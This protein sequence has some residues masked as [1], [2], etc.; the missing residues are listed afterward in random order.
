MVYLGIYGYIRYIWVYEAILEYIGV[1][2]GILLIFGYI[3]VDKG[4]FEYFMEISGCWL[5][6]A[7]SSQTGYKCPYV[8]CL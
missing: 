1:Y 8:N 6:F 2:M 4:I 3:R 7:Q 5:H